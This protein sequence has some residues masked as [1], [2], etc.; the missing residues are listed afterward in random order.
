MLSR[1]LVLTTVVIKPEGFSF[2]LDEFFNS[3]NP[4]NNGISS[5]STSISVSSNMTS[6][7]MSTSTNGQGFS[8]SSSTISGPGLETSIS[9][10]TSDGQSVTNL[11]L[12][13]SATYGHDDILAAA[14]GSNVDRL[15]NDIVQEAAGSGGGLIAGIV[16]GIVAALLIGG[17]VAFCCMKRKKTTTAAAGDIFEHSRSRTFTIPGAN[18]GEDSS[19]L[20]PNAPELSEQS[21]SSGR[22]EGQIKGSTLVRRRLEEDQIESY[23]ILSAVTMFAGAFFAFYALQRRFKW[24]VVSTNKA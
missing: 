11:T 9:V 7:S 8:Y 22:D 5:T 19:S 12:P 23:E 20:T 4:G 15:N 21:V 13:T 10:T 2:D 24:F 1:A 18:F 6:T 3:L 17:A 14:N 16:A